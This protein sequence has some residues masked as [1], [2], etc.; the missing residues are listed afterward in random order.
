MDINYLLL[1]QSFREATGGILNP[2]FE[3]VTKL[4]ETSIVML[5]IGIIY[6]G[7]DKRKGIFL[8]FS[9][10]TNRIVN[11]FLKITACV[12]RPWIR[13]ARIAPVPEAQADATGYSFPSGHTANAVSVWG[14]CALADKQSRKIPKWLRIVLVIFV[15]LIGFSR[16]YLG[17][18]TPQDVIVAMLVGAA[19]LF[20]MAKLMQV[21]DRRPDL[22]IWV[23]LGGTLLCVLLI[24]YA[25]L[26]S[27]PADYAADG[28]VI[29]EGSKMAVDSFKNAGMGIGFFLGWLIERRFVKFSTDGNR[30][31]QAFRLLF[32]IFTYCLLDE[33]SGE[34]AKALINVGFAEGLAKALMQFICV[35][36][37]V[38]GGPAIVKLLTGLFCKNGKKSKKE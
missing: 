16:N 5:F 34:A 27:Y 6:W 31:E 37:F 28:S 10:Y 3:A 35:F 22:D 21:L 38:A 1:L 19:V 26:K 2:F 11:G 30:G 9:L 25:M 15:L 33:F 12:Y 18:H 36:Y 20:F 24:V 4:G 32:C 13:D 17:V 14:G 29:V 7:F 23:A 8:M